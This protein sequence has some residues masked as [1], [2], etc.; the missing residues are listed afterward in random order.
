MPGMETSTEHICLIGATGFVGRH[1]VS[2]LARRN[3]RVQV[4]AR[5]P[6]KV[7]LPGTEITRLTHDFDFSGVDAVVNLAGILHGPQSFDAVHV[8]LPLKI[9]R[10]CL[11]QKVPR[12]L[13]MSALGASPE[14]PSEYLKSK[15]R[16]EEAVRS[17]CEGSYTRC[18]IFRPSVILGK[19]DHFVT[20]F[21]GLV[22]NF[23]IIPVACP[24]SR[25][26]P[27]LV[28]DV[29]RAFVDSMDRTD[30]ADRTFCLC[31]PQVYSLIDLVRTIAKGKT[32]LII[33]LPDSLSRLQARLLEFTPGPLMTRDNYLSLMKDNVCEGPFPFEWKP[34]SITEVV[35]CAALRPRAP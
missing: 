30:S 29:V 12:L 9:A 31:G 3:K 32:R 26:Q 7:I 28:E 1:L 25:L 17:V 20:L 10:A 8:D 24:N 14:G 5:N 27:I 34:A 13:H 18:T 15:W 16:G 21:S 33:P 19:D 6:D 22:R 23:P 4:L 11:E 35:T 2:E